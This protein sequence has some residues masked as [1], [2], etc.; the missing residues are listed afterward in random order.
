MKYLFLRND[1]ELMTANEITEDELQEVYEE[2]LTVIRFENGKFQFA[3]VEQLEIE[4]EADADDEQEYEYD[5][6]WKD[7]FPL[8]RAS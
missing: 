5:I 3:E 6:S 7:T 1:D 4:G 2:D 8:R